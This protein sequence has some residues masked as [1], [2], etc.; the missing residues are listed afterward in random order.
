VLIS[1]LSFQ[2]LVIAYTANGNSPRR[3][4]E[5][6]FFRLMP[7][8]WIASN[9]VGDRFD[10]AS[11]VPWDSIF[12]D[13][14][15]SMILSPK[16]PWIEGSYWTLTVEIVFYTVI[17]AIL[18]QN[19]FA[20]IDKILGLAGVAVST[21]AIVTLWLSPRYPILSVVLTSW[22]SKLFLL[23]NGSEFVLG[24]FLYLVLFI[25]ATS[26]RLSV[27]AIC[28]LGSCAQIS[29]HI[30]SFPFYSNG[31]VIM[32]LPLILWLAAVLG[33]VQSV[34]FNALITNRFKSAMP[35]VR[36]MGLLTYPLYLV[37]SP[38]GLVVMQRDYQS[39]HSPALA[40]I[41]AVIAVLLA[42]VAILLTE[43]ALRAMVKSPVRRGADRAQGW[44]FGPRLAEP[45]SPIK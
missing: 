22:P 36:Q 42:A 34:R 30:L 16:G 45:T 2:G 13:Y 38:L 5:G 20:E 15:R 12:A 17:F 11:T 44:F 26:F 4:A 43:P 28:L 32:W 37:H 21:L 29:H 7:S 35:A 14:L 24:V 25:E 10:V 1:F 31:G 8:V 18:C 33:M 6:R 3:F 19:M 41:A 23:N 40:L 39:T 9:S 27:L